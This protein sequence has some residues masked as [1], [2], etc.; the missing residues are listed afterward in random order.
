MIVILVVIGVPLLAAAMTG[1]V[2]VRAGVAVRRRSLRPLLRPVFCFQLALAGAGVAALAFGWGFTTG[3]NIPDPDAQCNGIGLDLA[4]PRRHLVTRS[5]F[6]VSIV[7]SD[8]RDGRNG[9]EQVPG[10]VNPTVFTAGGLGI[11]AL[12]ALPFTIRLRRHRPGQ[13][14]R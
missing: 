1:A 3:F 5:V 13:G 6:P 12:V 7:C 11:A 10:W 14:R 9:D 8:G 2:L 4:A